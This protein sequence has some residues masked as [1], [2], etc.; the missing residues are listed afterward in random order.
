MRSKIFIATPMYGGKA[1]ALYVHSLLMLQ[2]LCVDQNVD[3]TWRFLTTESLITRGRNCLVNDFLQSDC[4][5]F[6]SIDA[7]I[8]FAAGDVLD[9][10]NSGL[11]IV[12]GLYPM[13]F[14]DWSR[15]QERILSGSDVSTVFQDCSPAV[16]NWLADTAGP[17]EHENL[18]EIQEAGT[19]FMCVKR[20]V[21]E[22]MQ[23]HVPWYRGNRPEELNTKIYEFFATSIDPQ[24]EVLLSEDYHFCHLWRKLGGK[25][26]AKLDINLTHIG[27]FAYQNQTKYLQPWAAMSRANK[28]QS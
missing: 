27:D 17:G 13:K 6:M 1:S 3:L 7:D 21:F 18:V 20:S 15:V 2:N 8:G 16:C 26:H 19:G 10:V 24:S 25:V 4:Q 14:I 11:D 9:L 23:P 5:H 28:E 12:C 22:I